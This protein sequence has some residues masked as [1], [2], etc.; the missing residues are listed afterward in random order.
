MN[1]TDKNRMKKQT[2]SVLH[3][4]TATNPTGQT[5]NNISHKQYIVN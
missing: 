2:K 4:V 1:Y 5:I 3:K